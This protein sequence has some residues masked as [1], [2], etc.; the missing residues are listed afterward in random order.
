MSMVKFRCDVCG[1][2]FMGNDLSEVMDIKCPRCRDR[3]MNPVDEN[4]DPVYRRVVVK[5]NYTKQIA[6]LNT[7]ENGKKKT[8]KIPKNLSD[9]PR[10]IAEALF[11]NMFCNTCAYWYD[12]CCHRCVGGEYACEGKYHTERREKEMPKFNNNKLNE[13]TTSVHVETKS[14]FVEKD[15]VVSLVKMLTYFNGYFTALEWLSNTVTLSEVEDMDKFID[16]VYELQSNLELYSQ[17]A[18]NTIIAALTVPEYYN[19]D[20]VLLHEADWFAPWKIDKECR[21]FN[22]YAMIYLDEILSYRGK[23]NPAYKF[24]RTNVALIL[25]KE[26][27]E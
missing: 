8:M 27:E 25:N 9:K 11:H 7:H 14:G 21:D 24:I 6:Q 17:K 3:Y 12:N 20:F 2:E 5:D 1:C 18:K 22:T 13:L 4:D 15:V 26:D 23:Q 10:E 16:H 19:A